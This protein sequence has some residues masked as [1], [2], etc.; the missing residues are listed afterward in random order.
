MEELKEFKKELEEMLE[1]VNAKLEEDDKKYWLFHNGEVMQFT[2][3]DHRLDIFNK[4]IGNYFK[5]KQEAEEYLEDLKV[6][7]EIKKIAE[8]LNGDEKIDWDDDAQQ[9]YFLIY[10]YGYS[11][12]EYHHEYTWKSEG[13]IYCLDKK[14]ANE[15]VK[16]IGLERLEN[17]LKRN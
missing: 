5:T 13:T 10:N 12:F 15:C 7:V 14:F 2:D 16:R 9:K 4:E 1:K 3:D 6:K 17:Y 8:E 11:E